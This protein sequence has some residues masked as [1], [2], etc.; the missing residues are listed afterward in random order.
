MVW[1]TA[2]QENYVTG[3]AVSAPAA[4]QGSFSS[5]SGFGAGLNEGKRHEEPFAELAAEATA[6]QNML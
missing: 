1:G 2:N 4:Q 5:P 3:D 6:K